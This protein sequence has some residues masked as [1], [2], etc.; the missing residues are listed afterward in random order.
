M[1][2]S[3]AMLWM[4]SWK[5]RISESFLMIA[6]SVMVVVLSA[7]HQSKSALALSIPR[8]ETAGQSGGSGLGAAGLT[9][10]LRR[11]LVVELHRP[12][13]LFDLDDAL[14]SNTTRCAQSQLE[15]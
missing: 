6:A 7:K 13:S 11:L 5:V 8:V 4:V 10:A 3:S 12:L 9:V 14:C 15:T 1:S 2:F